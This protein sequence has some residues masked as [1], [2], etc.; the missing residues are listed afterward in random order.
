MFSYS[1]KN[2][3][4]LF[5]ALIF[6]IIFWVIAQIYRSMNLIDNYQSPESSFNRGVTDAEYEFKY[7][8]ARFKSIGGEYPFV[9][10]NDFSGKYK[11]YAPQ[12]Y[13]LCGTGLS[14]ERIALN[15]KNYGYNR[16]YVT[17]YNG[18]LIY[19]IEKNTVVVPP[20]P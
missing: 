12:M 17:S 9:N 14:I 7:N 13:F 4:I 16:N 1:V 18:H 11:N 2:I 5:S 6:M 10:E 3:F 19:L 8:Y 20:S 15:L